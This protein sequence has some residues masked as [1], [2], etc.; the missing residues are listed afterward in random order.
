[1][2]QEGYQRADSL[3]AKAGSNPLLQAAAKA[4]ADRLRK[5]ADDKAAAIVREADQRADSLVAAARQQAGR[6]GERP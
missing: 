3:V 6:I 5:E 1:M 4:A 2:K